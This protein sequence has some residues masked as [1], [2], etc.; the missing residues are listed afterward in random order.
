MDEKTEENSHVTQE[1]KDL[2]LAKLRR[3][4]KAATECIEDIQ[5]ELDTA[6]EDDPDYACQEIDR[7]LKYYTQNLDV[8]E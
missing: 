1:D 4:L 6:G 7:D 8:D 5:R 2:T 3:Q